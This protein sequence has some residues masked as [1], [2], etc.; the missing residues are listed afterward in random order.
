[1]SNCIQTKPPSDSKGLPQIKTDEAMFAS[2]LE[3][4]ARYPGGFASG[5]A[6]PESEGEICSLLKECSARKSRILPIGAQSSLTG[7]AT[8]FGEVL[9]STERM[10]KVIRIDE[11]PD[12]AGARVVAGPGITL[13]ALQKQ[14]REAGYF[15]PPVPTYDLAFLGGSVATNAGG[16]ATF[17]YGVTR[18]WVYRIRVASASGEVLEITRGECKANDAGE[19]EIRQSNGRPIRFT[20]PS[21][22]TPSIKKVSAGYYSRPG[23]DL[24]DLF[25]GSEG[26]LGVL[27]EIEVRVIPLPA[28]ELTGLVFVSED[29]VALEWVDFVRKESEATWSGRE[30][31]GIDFRAAEFLDEKSLSI[32]RGRGKD[33]ELRIPVPDDARAAVYFE[34]EL[35]RAVSQGEVEICLMAVWEGAEIPEECRDPVLLSASRLFT[36]LRDRNLLE[37]L[38]L[39][40][41]GQTDRHRALRD[42]R[43]AVPIAVNE[44]LKERQLQ[45]SPEITKVAGDMI[46]PFEHIGEILDIYRT[47]FEEIGIEYAVWGH[48]SDGNLHPNALPRSVEEMR[49]AEDVILEFGREVKR[50][51]GAPLSEHGVGRNRIKQRL[52]ADFYGDKGVREMAAIKKALDPN[53]ILSPGVIFPTSFLDEAATHN[54]G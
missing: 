10:E 1:M 34:V 16:A 21:Y 22:Q 15:Y 4:A 38:E 17:K 9:L 41:P 5:I 46:V 18:D 20:I 44:I 30:V 39:A 24:I 33:R 14:L 54:G 43:E 19:F 49:K 31:A 42:F 13:A 7:G 6:F 25:V 37:N 48:L 47:G 27:T 3:D 8:P 12:G 51:G 52:L 32:I 23:M 28:A 50:L 35:D 53:G 45:Y 11:E 2:Y 29:S 36:S 40:F 26:T